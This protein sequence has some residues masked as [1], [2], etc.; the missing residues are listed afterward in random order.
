MKRNQDLSPSP[1]EQAAIGNLVTKVQVVLDN[2][3]VAPGDF[4]TCVSCHSD[5]P[6]NILLT[7]LIPAYIAIRR[8]A[9][10]WIVQKGHH[11]QWQQCGRCGGY[12]Q[13]TADKGGL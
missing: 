1:T 13:N 10:S 6:L 4:N 11:S 8:S 9:S 12:S 7:Q 5:F 2:L 3:V